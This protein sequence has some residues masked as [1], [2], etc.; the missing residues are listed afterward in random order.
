MRR[1]VRKHDSCCSFANAPQQLSISRAAHTYL[2][3]DDNILLRVADTSALALLDA[4]LAAVVRADAA[5]WPVK[6]Q[7]VPKHVSLAWRGI[8]VYATLRCGSCK[9]ARVTTHVAAA[10]CTL[11]TTM[12]PVCAAPQTAQLPG[13]SYIVASSCCSKCYKS[14][15]NRHLY[16][17]LDGI[18]CRVHTFAH[19]LVCTRAR[20]ARWYAAFLPA[21]SAVQRLRPATACGTVCRSSPCMLVSV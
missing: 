17:P 10:S 12:L 21:A 15:A 4:N 18:C 16:A 6:L 7:R 3:G 13:T 20:Q 1:L 9:V 14:S 2:A 11:G 5:A 8:A 19:V